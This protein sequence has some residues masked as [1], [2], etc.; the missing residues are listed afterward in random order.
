MVQRE[1]LRGAEPGESGALLVAVGDA[2]AGEVIRGEFHLHTVA[3]QH[4]NI[5]LAH[6]AREVRENFMAVLQR[7]PESSVGEHFTYHSLDL[8]YVFCHDPPLC[9][10]PVSQNRPSRTLP[11]VA[12]GGNGRYSG[13]MILPLSARQIRTLEQHL[14]QGRTECPHCGGTLERQVVRPP[15]EVAYVRD[16]VWVICAAC[17]ASAVVDRRR[18]ERVWNEPP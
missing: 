2:S 11:P 3:L 15:P 17:G 14:A 9:G 13:A 12:W 18:I 6:L 7:D 5:M 1:C 8:N 4:T 16:R 10:M